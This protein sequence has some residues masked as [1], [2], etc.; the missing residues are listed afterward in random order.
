VR[1]RAPSLL[2]THACFVSQSDCA[3]GCITRVLLGYM[4][5]I[6]AAH[7]N[8][9]VLVITCHV[10]EPGARPARLEPDRLERTSQQQITVLL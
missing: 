6:V 2:H 7:V 1:L 4:A 5:L 3:R 8:E 10:H 9:Y